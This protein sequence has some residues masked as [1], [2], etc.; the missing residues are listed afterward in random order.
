M[1]FRL[2]AD[3]HVGCVRE[4]NE[5][6]ILVGSTFL[7]N[8]KL[9]WIFN[10]DE[11]ERFI[12]AVADGMGGHNSGEVASSDTLHN[13]HYFF[14]DIP[15]GLPTSDFNEAIHVWLKSINSMIESKGLVD[16]IYKDMGT[17][18]VALVHYG[19]QFYWLNCGDSRLYIMHKGKLRRLTT[20][21]SLNELLGQ[22]KHSNIL[23]NCIGGGCKTSYIDIVV[24]TNDIQPNDTIV[25]CSDGL[26]DMIS[27]KEMADMLTKGYDASQ[28]RKAAIDA[29]GS[30][31]ISACVIYTY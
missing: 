1:E 14:N 7:R 26:T 16:P 13:L 6:M 9:S 11:Q 30:D 15:S 25:L 2:T 4:N 18:L 3:C 22:K 23:T 5:D 21:H 29:G 10:T 27:D 12:V 20:D 28:L 24:C 19:G 31:N 17:T 8:D